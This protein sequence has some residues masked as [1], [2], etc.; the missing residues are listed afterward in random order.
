MLNPEQQQFVEQ[1]EPMIGWY[2]GTHSACAEIDDIYGML[3]L[4]LCACAERY[5][6]E[7][8]APTTYI[9]H[10]FN[11]EL[12]H[13]FAQARTAKRRLNTEAT[14]LQ[15]SMSKYGDTQENHSTV[16]ET[17]P[18]P[19]HGYTE[20]ELKDVLKHARLDPRQRVIVW[21]VLHGETCA[22]IARDL[23]VSRQCANKAYR[24]ALTILK[25]VII[26]S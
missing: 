1:Y 12:G 4:R 13:Y 14:S 20:I 2:I 3:A 16:Q 6:P 23:G 26:S 5:R 10:C 8:G 15:P 21:R 24:D 18:S 7:L 9:V 11:G 25:K 22:E 19:E 17:L